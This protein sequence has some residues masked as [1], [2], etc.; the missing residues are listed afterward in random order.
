M[1]SRRSVD[2]PLPTPPPPPPPPPTTLAE[3]AF[4]EANGGAAG[5][6]VPSLGKSVKEQESN[7]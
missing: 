3:I 2:D 6:D 7:S 5:N 4:E 1:V